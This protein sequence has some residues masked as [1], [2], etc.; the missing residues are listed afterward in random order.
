MI[1][2]PPRSTL[3]PYT[4]LF[5]SQG[6]GVCPPLPPLRVAAGQARHRRQPRLDGSAGA[7]DARGSRSGDGFVVAPELGIGEV[8]TPPDQCPLRLHRPRL[9][10]AEAWIEAELADGCMQ[11]DPRQ[12]PLVAAGET[13]RGEPLVDGSDEPLA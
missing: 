9:L 6:R 8:V 3:F 12:Q 2:R 13:R 7:S 1:R 4:T 10:A 11:R 5:R